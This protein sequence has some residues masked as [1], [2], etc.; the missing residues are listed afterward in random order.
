[1]VDSWYSLDPVVPERMSQVLKRSEVVYINSAPST[2]GYLLTLLRERSHVSRG[3]T[4]IAEANRY[5]KRTKVVFC[6]NSKKGLENRSS[7]FEP[8]ISLISF[9]R[10]SGPPLRWGWVFLERTQIL[11]EIQFT[12][13]FIGFF[14]V[15][16]KRF[17]RSFSH[18]ILTR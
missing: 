7:R 14:F 8:K 17:V 4:E 10:G 12:T 16:T 15:E 6:T 1:M 5:E 13:H 18:V 11:S 9:S 2:P 3:L